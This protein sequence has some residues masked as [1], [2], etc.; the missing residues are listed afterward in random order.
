MQQRKIL[1]SF[2]LTCI[3]LFGASGAQAMPVLVHQPVLDVREAAPIPIQVTVTDPDGAITEVRL[4]YRISSTLGYRETL[5][6]SAGFNYTGVIPGEMVTAAGIEYY[7]Q[8]I[9]QAGQRATSPPINAA[10]APHRIVVRDLIT[11]PVLTL[12]SPQ[13][14]SVITPLDAVIV[15]GVDAGK[16]KADLSTLKVILDEKD[17]TTEMEKSE[18][19]ISYVPAEAMSPGLH[20]LQVTIRNQEG[21]EAKSPTWAFEVSAEKAASSWQEEMKKELEEP[22]FTLHGNIGAAVQNALLTKKPGDST[23]LYQPEGWL[24]RINANF[25]GKAGQLTLLG[26]AS[27]TSEETPGRQPVNRFRL[28]LATPSLN[29][30]LGDMYPEF[31][32]FSL[33][34][35]FVRGG[36][37]RLIMGD[38]DQGH[39]ELH[40]LGGFNQLAIGGVSSVDPAVERAGTFERIIG[41]LRWLSDFAAGT[42]FSL[43]ASG[44]VDNSQSL[45]EEEWGG[46]YPYYNVLGSA[47]V[48]IKIPFTSSFFSLWYGEYGAAI[49][50]EEG[51]YVSATTDDALRGG[52]RWE[53]GDYRS[54]VSCEYKRTGANY[55]NETN[56][57]L[58]GDSQ[59]IFSDGQLSVLGSDLILSG[60]VDVYADNVDGQKNYEIWNDASN[61]SITVVATTDTTHMA[62]MISYRISPYVSNISAG[63]SIHYQKDQAEPYAIIYNQTDVLNLG[64]GTQF[65]LAADQLLVN[66]TYS[67]SRY[68]D[69]AEAPLSGNVDTS[70]FLTSLMYLRSTWSVAAGFGINS[71]LT[72]EA[73]L[74]AWSYKMLYYGSYQQRLDYTLWNVRANWKLI[75][76][77]LDLGLIFEN[78][79]SEDDLSVVGARLITAGVNSRYYFSSRHS[80]GLELSNIDYQ[81]TITAENS[82]AEFVV[83]INY[84]LGF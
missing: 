5:M 7:L 64:I 57:W 11:A 77:Q 75:P 26:S 54:H 30:S 15:I 17:I 14:G 40:L 62:G 32:Y 37:L 25:T 56:P 2:G 21:M 81:D 73:S 71:S 47:D 58:V 36:S 24:N 43:N 39:S 20:G 27:L 48:H 79:I 69:L 10:A 53:W 1:Y 9:N 83:N 28:D 38:A 80:M 70:S 45:D 65:P 46:T 16:S 13:A 68:Q 12:L 33:Y 31:T 61:N 29:V 55:I 50:Y 76:G 59:G 66:L 19:M 67:L 60:E 52:T 78:L 51:N 18:T 34:N 41:G 35:A 84:T 23:S 74:G 49:G 44:A 4:Y 8:A 6:Q 42:G 82:Y 72:D 22:A 3:M 63:Y